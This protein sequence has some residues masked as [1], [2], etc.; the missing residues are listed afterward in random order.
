MI[1]RGPLALRRRALISLMPA[2]FTVGLFGASSRP[3]AHLTTD[4]IVNAAKQR[5]LNI[6]VRCAAT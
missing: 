6:A 5:G 2:G 1:C 3:Y 4:E